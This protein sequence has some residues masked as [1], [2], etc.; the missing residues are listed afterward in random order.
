MALLGVISDPK[1]AQANLT[2]L[3]GVL[4]QIEKDRA[5]LDAERSSVEAE[6][7]AKRSTVDA[8][9]S[10][11]RAEVERSANAYSKLHEDLEEK[12]RRHADRLAE[13]ERVLERF[14]SYWKVRI[15]R[16][17]GGPG[18]AAALV[19]IPGYFAD[20]PDDEP[21]DAHFRS[22]AEGGFDHDTEL[23]RTG[24]SGESF[25]RDSTIT[26]CRPMRRGVEA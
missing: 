11:R 17:Y 12:K 22:V 13:A 10:A 26:R 14:R 16:E 18:G 6:L 7:A 15:E 23:T 24:F 4:A 21:K 9:C 5:A 1:T 25:S 8:E 20:V 3:R 2:R 19:S